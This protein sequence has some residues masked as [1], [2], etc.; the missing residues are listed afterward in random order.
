MKAILILV[1]LCL[2]G[3]LDINGILNGKEAA[4]NTF[5][6]QAAIHRRNQKNIVCSGAIVNSRLILTGARLLYHADASPKDLFAVVGTVYLN[7]DSSP[8]I[9]YDIE[10]IIL[11]RSYNLRTYENDIALLRTVQEIQFTSFIQPV[12]LPS[13]DRID[14]VNANASGWGQTDV[15]KKNKYLLWTMPLQVCL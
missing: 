1:L 2:F 5:I 6:Y 14:D 3:V 8:G 12:F 7:N 9:S 15:S 13:N 10:E 11:H 4:E